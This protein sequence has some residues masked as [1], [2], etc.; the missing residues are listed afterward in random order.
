MEIKVPIVASPTAAHGASGSAVVESVVRDKCERLAVISPRADNLCVAV[1][2]WI[3][4][5]TRVKSYFYSNKSANKENDSY[6]QPFRLAR[7]LATSP[8]ERNNTET[9]C[10]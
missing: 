5:K 3:P 7:M 1:Y 9:K 4:F 8:D 10:Y 6:S 2:R